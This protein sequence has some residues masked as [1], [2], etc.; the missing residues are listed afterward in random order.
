[1]Q[2]LSG[3]FPLDITATNDY[4]RRVKPAIGLLISL[5]V[6]LLVVAGSAVIWYLSATAE[7][8]RKPAAPAPA[9]PPPKAIPVRP[10]AKR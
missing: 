4:Q 5:L 10:P 6:S 8:S 7:F 3:I 2:A 1:M 9:A